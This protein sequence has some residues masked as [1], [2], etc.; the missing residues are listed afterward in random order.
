[1][2]CSGLKAPHWSIHTLK[3]HFHTGNW[4]NRQRLLCGLF[5]SWSRAHVAWNGVPNIFVNFSK[6]MSL[7]VDSTE[8]LFIFISV[9][10]SL[11]LLHSCL[12]LEVV[13][14]TAAGQQLK[15]YLYAFNSSISANNNVF[16]AGKKQA[17][18]SSADC[19]VS[20]QTLTMEDWS[21]PEASTF[22]LSFSL[23]FLSSISE[24]CCLSF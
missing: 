5:Y 4:L 21:W 11:L 2:T 22:L 8:T 13:S 1:M 20:L 7:K 23:G 12:S 14:M 16:T 18:S 6:W 15:D 19:S 17:L 10:S 24:L 3:Y 9:Q